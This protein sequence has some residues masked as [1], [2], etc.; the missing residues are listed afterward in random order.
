MNV[1]RLRAKNR[2]LKIIP[3]T[4]AQASENNVWIRKRT[5]KGE[6]MSE[7]S[8]KLITILEPIP[9]SKLPR[10]W[11]AIVG[12]VEFVGETEDEVREEALQYIRRDPLVADWL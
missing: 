8:E 11:T 12:S 1:E 5:A 6:Q 2:H 10:Y 7:S 4:L 3:L 9:G